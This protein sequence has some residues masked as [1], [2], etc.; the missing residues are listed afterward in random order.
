MNRKITVS[1][2]QL[3]KLLIKH[4]ELIMKD[5]LVHKQYAGRLIQDVLADLFERIVRAALK[6]LR[7]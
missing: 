4:F 6:E 5:P 7:P 2:D 3:Q 1:E